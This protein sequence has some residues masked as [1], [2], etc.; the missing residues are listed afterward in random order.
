MSEDENYIEKKVPGRIY[1]SKTFPI[2]VRT[3][4]ASGAIATAARSARYFDRVFPE[5]EG[6]AFAE[7]KGEMVIHTTPSG[8]AQTKLFVIEDPRKVRSVIFQSFKI[9]EDGAVPHRTSHFSL[10]GDQIDALMDMIN[11]AKQG[12][13]QTNGKFRLD[14]QALEHLD[15]DPQ[16]IRELLQG[17]TALLQTILNEDLTANDVVAT[18]YRKKQIKRF[19]ALLEDSAAFEAELA[20][21]SGAGPEA[22]WQNFF[23]ENHWIFG[24]TLFV[25]ATGGIDSG[26]LERVVSGS[27]VA[28][29]GK[30]V[31]ALLRTRGRIGALCFVELKTHTTPLQR[32][33]PYRSGVWSAST[34]LVGAISQIHRTVQLAEDN[35]KRLLRPRDEKTGEVSGPDAYLIRP[36][37]VVVCGH[38]DQFVK[39]GV[40]NEDRYYSFE[41]FRRH[42]QGPEIV[43]YDELLERAK[44][45]VEYP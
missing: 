39:G 21:I 24:G 34:E 13:F 41:L 15:V 45:L 35:V 1:A 9:H 37:S 18:A 33:K 3:V 32:D 20:R 14:A 36:R 19:E 17:N 29:P 23:E 2:A 31:D 30:K 8:K 5:Q 44:L 26:K 28:N 25:S 6:E 10:H 7:I 22:V 11:L 43:T 40:V 38:L 16:A 12:E 4:D 27:S 42:L